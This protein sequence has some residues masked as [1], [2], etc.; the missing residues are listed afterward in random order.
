MSYNFTQSVQL[1]RK[2]YL[3]GKI[4][5]FCARQNPIDQ[6]VLNAVNDCSAYGVLLCDLC[7]FTGRQNVWR[8]VLPLCSGCKKKAASLLQNVCSYLI[9]RRRISGDQNF[10]PFM[11]NSSER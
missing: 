11:I 4:R 9:A 5:Y 7:V 6:P 2:L 8:N 1:E 10:S 3:T